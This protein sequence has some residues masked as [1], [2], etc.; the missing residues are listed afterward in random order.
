M[1]SL[2]RITPD[3]FTITTG[4]AIFW[5]Y[6]VIKNEQIRTQ[7]SKKN[8]FN[9]IFLPIYWE[10]DEVMRNTSYFKWTAELQ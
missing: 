7:L 5:K 9:D 3:K 2:K 4:S 10:N 8:M 1:W 6:L